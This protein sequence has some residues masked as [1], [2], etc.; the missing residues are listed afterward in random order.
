[1]VCDVR[2]RDSLIHQAQ[3][4]PKP[5]QRPSSVPKIAKLLPT[6][7]QHQFR[8]IPSL[9]HPKLHALAIRDSGVFVA[10]CPTPSVQ[11]TNNN[12][13]PDTPPQRSHLTQ[14]RILST[15]ASGTVNLDK[16][17][18]R[19]QG[20]DRTQSRTMESVVDVNLRYTFQPRSQQIA[21]TIRPLLRQ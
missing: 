16:I 10:R 21:T 19:S 11:Q 8:L 18:I 5:D 13:P 12:S 17:N 1:M 15:C 20:L 3:S 14:S 6:F 4:Q 2:R 7:Q 9:A